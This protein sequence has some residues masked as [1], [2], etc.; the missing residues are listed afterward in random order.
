[1]LRLCV[2]FCCALLWTAGCKTS[3]E[4][5]PAAGDTVGTTPGTPAEASDG[6]VSG[7]GTI[8]FVALEGGFYGL[9]AQDSTRYNPLNLEDRYR[10]D[11][12][13]V[14]FRIRLKPDQVT[15]Q[16][17]GTPAEVIEM[18]PLDVIDQP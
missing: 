17:W 13:E 7:T 5:A 9:Y 15:I 8:R 14:R 16:M 10:R 6:I 2:L 4:P 12:L 11:G 1:M 18:E 3:E